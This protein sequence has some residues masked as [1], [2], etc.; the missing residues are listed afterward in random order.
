VH[1]AVD[2]AGDPAIGGLVDGIV[3]LHG[4]AGP[5][6]VPGRCERLDAYAAALATGTA[7]QRGGIGAAHL[8][9]GL[10]VG[11]LSRSAGAQLVRATALGMEVQLRLER[12]LG[13]AGDG[14]GR[15][16]AGACAVIG[17]AV[18]AG[19][20]A[21]LDGAQ[22]ARA[23]GLAVSQTVDPGEGAGSAPGTGKVAA[24]GVLAVLLARTGFS[25]PDT[26]LDG[27]RGFFAVLSPR[28]QPARVLEGL[29][30][31]W[32]VAPAD[33]DLDRVGGAGTL[34]AAVRDLPTAST[35]RPL[36]DAA[37]PHGSRR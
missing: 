31:T 24:N 30:S 8:G 2:A 18:T 6:P 19:L 15:H 27:D 12:A 16:L 26:A 3:R 33:P 11:W 5:V 14:M 29:G 34:G 13:S 25:A 32:H 10:S 1:A 21:Q 4:A 7:A 35:L 28:S 23:V 17:A 20:L 37:T 36:V 22:L 9:A